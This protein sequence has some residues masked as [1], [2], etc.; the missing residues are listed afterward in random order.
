M[1]PR[2]LLA[3][4]VLA[5]LIA[6]VAA[7]LFVGRDG[8]QGTGQGASTDGEPRGAL[9]GGGSTFLNP[10]MQAWS[11]EFYRATG[12]RVT[13]NYQSIGSGAGTAQLIARKLDFG[14]S[15]VPLGRDR[16]EELG[17][18]IYQFPVI[19]GSI[20][21]IYNVPEASYASTGQRIRLSPE[22]VALIY[23]GEVR[24][25]C[26]ERI[27][28]LN[29]G[30]ADRLPCRDIV[31]VH[32]SDGSGTTGAFTL[33]LSRNYAPWASEVGHG[34]T[35]EWPADKVAKGL[36]A[37]GNEGVSQAVLRV[38]YSIGYVEY[39]YWSLNADRYDEVGG[40]A[41]VLNVNDGE[42][43]FPSPDA[44]ALG[45]SEALRSYAEEHGAYPSAS[46]DWGPVTEALVTPPRG[47]PI[48]A[49][50]YILVWRDYR[51][52]GY[53]D[54]ATRAGLIRGF[55][56]WVLTEGQKPENVVEG[57]IP[58]PP[59]VAEIGLKALEGVRG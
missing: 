10:Q 20:V 23:M 2:R 31:A 42:Y 41:E 27:R 9:V 5:A 47:Y 38:P 45:V 3:A 55:F 51:A 53:A 33:W 28:R 39:A 18:R 24:Q 44:V 19:V 29:P 4:I 40:V 48:A 34:Y 6:T 26:D 43:Y 49:F 58:L 32:R 50:T 8:V 1:K 30:L 54:P 57:Y 56:R 15:D 35:V 52:E 14:A 13:V 16:L 11:R 46:E 17:G 21:I 37:K 7:T 25:W 59:E 12:G 36:G 22:V